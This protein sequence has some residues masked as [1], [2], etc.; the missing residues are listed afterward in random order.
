[1]R[2]SCMLH[3]LLPSGS[4]PSYH[5]FPSFKL[6]TP[7]QVLDLK[8]TPKA[9][10]NDLLDQFVTIT[11]TKSELEQTSFLSTLDMDPP[12]TSVSLLSTTSPAGSRA[13]LPALLTSRPESVGSGGGGSAMEGLFSALKSPPLSGPPTGT[14]SETSSH[15][16]ERREVFSD[17]RRFVSFGLRRDTSNG[18]P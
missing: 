10:Q 1:M 5:S 15:A 4:S 11:S 8:G 7:C 16:A 13:N 14:G 2:S 3:I 12:A 9:V 6:I 17:L 18:Q